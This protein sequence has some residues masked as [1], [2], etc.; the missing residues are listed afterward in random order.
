[1]KQ[2]KDNLNVKVEIVS[3]QGLLIMVEGQRY[4][5]AFSDFPFLAELPAREV[6]DIEYCGH[7][8]IRWESSDIDLNTEILSNPDAY[9]FSFQGDMHEAAAS[10]GKI[11]GAKKTDI[12]VAASRE[13]GR[14]GG[15]PRKEQMVSLQ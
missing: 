13:N 3:P 4:F 8:H 10:L 11:G 7:G 15:R 9:P 12:K 6:F 14:K 1:M 5:A 2:K